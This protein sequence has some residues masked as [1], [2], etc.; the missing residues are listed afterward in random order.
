MKLRGLVLNLCFCELFIYSHDRSSYF[1]A[2]IEGPIAWKYINFSNIHECGNWAR[3]RAVSN[4]GIHKS[5]LLSSVFA[6]KM[7]N[8][9][10]YFGPL[11]C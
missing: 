7:F 9:D 5:D 1:V 11:L 6:V 8:D 4:L 2:E 10:I 3:G